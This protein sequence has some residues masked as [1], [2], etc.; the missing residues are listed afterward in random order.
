MLLALIANAT[1]AGTLEAWSPGDF[2]EDYLASDHGWRAGWE[3]DEWYG[4]EYQ[5]TSYA[6]PLTDSSDDGRFGDRGA[7]DNWLWNPAETVK[8]GEL[9]VGVYTNDDDGFGLVFGASQDARYLLLFC[10]VE[11]ARGSDCP[12][13][14]IE[15]PGS[16]LL[17]IEGREVEV[18]DTA[19][20]VESGE[21]EMIVAMN[22]GVLTVTAAGDEL[23]SLDVPDDFVLN[24][25]GFY[26]YNQGLYEDNG[27]QD[28]SSSYYHDVGLFLQDDDNDG[29]ADDVDN[30]EKVANADQAD[31]DGDGKGTACDDAEVTDTGTDDTG[32]TGGPDGGNNND[33]TDGIGLTAPGVCSCAVTDPAAGVLLLGL[34]ALAS[35]RRRRS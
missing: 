10:G 13:D 32:D 23:Y 16:A 18:L 34:A 22:D 17:R 7:H 5:G 25:V 15:A 21:A 33:G 29:V 6:T 11:D 8:Q 19:S 20:S 28:G 24:G 14:E 12:T 26:G 3:E 31:A 27:Q 30:C 9:V 1:L 35:S 2:P 4:V